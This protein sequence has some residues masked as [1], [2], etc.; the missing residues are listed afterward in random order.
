[1]S[2]LATAP[3]DLKNRWNA[4]R[5]RNPR[6]RIR[7]AADELGVSELELL[8]TDLG[9]GVTRL[10]MDFSELFPRLASLGHVMGLTRNDACVIEVDGS[11]ENQDIFPHASQ[12]VSEGID[13]RIFPSYWAHA[14]AVEKEG[15]KPSRSIQVFEA[16]GTASHKVFLRGESDLGAFR[17]LVEDLRH[18]DQTA[19]VGLT[20]YPA[21]APERPDAEVD[22]E[23]LLEAWAGLTDTHEFFRLL[24]RFEV[25]RTQALRLAEGRFTRR[26]SRDAARQALTKASEREIPLMAFVGSRGTIQI[27]TGKVKR[28]VEHEGWFN[29]MDPGFNLHL[30]EG[31]I[32]SAWMVEKN[33]EGGVA[34]SLEVYDG[35]GRTI[36]LFFGVR[37]PGSDGGVAWKELTDELI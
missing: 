27:F 31:R 13:L 30:D 16:D 14:F 21:D 26:V 6:I 3:S 2:S 12:V 23:G 9:N 8:A 28:T 29:V 37:K 19:D 22:R 35:E 15:R 25:T 20:A 34:T 17:S 4:L 10:R 18:E 24:R 7:D 11:Y 33:G 36:V 1:M 32:A 5:E